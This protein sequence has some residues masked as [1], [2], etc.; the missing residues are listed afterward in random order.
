VAAGIV[1]CGLNQPSFVLTIASWLT[2]DVGAVAQKPGA[3]LQW[4]P[5]TAFLGLA[6]WGLAGVVGRPS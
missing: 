4:A 6:G 5:V 1:R 2:T 3:L